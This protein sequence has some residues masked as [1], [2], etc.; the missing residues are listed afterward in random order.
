VTREVPLTT[1]TDLATS[2]AGFAGARS[3]LLGSDDVAEA[4][5]AL[6]QL[7]AAS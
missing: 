3:G 6:E 4:A 5:K 7:E 2:F 1:S